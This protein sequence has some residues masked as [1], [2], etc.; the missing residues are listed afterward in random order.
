MAVR[1]E[2]ISRNSSCFAREDSPYFFRVFGILLMTSGV[3]GYDLRGD[4]TGTSGVCVGYAC[5]SMQ[6]A[7]G[8]GFRYYGVFT[9]DVAGKL[10]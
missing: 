7:I 6:C 3:Y 8:S 4:L 5:H 9:S 2:F 10:K 1:M